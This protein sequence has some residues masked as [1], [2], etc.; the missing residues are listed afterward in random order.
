MSH[1]RMRERERDRGCSRG[2]EFGGR[3]GSAVSR[4]PSPRRCWRDDWARREGRIRLDAA[5]NRIQRRA[6]L[7][8]LPP[9]LLLVSRISEE[10][11]PRSVLNYQ[12]PPRIKAVHPLQRNIG[13]CLSVCLSVTRANV[14][15]TRTTRIAASLYGASHGVERNVLFARRFPRAFSSS[16]VRPIATIR[17]EPAACHRRLIKHCAS[18]DTRN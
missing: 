18:S 11:F 16:L 13:A 8:K 5:L 6:P 4:V 1:G 9:L 3:L 15:N 17:N 2:I 7:L 12:P 10:R 14:K